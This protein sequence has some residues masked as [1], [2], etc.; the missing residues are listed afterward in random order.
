MDYKAFLGKTE[1]LV[2]P[3]FGGTRVEAASRRLRVQAGASHAAGWYE[4]KV[5]GRRATIVA[6]AAPPD[7][8]KLPAI[9]GHWA[10]GWI[11]AS[12]RDA[13]RVALPPDEEP[14][15]LQRCTGRRWHGGEVVLGSI[16]F[17]D[18]AEEQARLALEQGRSIADVKGATPSLRAAFGFAIVLDAARELGVEVSATEARAHAVRFAE[19]GRAAANDW[20]AGL[21]EERRRQEAEAAERLRQAEIAA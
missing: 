19:G 6:P 2:L 15:P 4:W 16:D 12:G 18:E 7:L 13:E 8:D 3:Y 5:D 11:F 1:T 17:E 20:L 14:A 21:V 9:R 10:G